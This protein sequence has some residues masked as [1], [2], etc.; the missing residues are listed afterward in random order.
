MDSKKQLIEL[1]DKAYQIYVPHISVDTVIFGFNNNELK[2]LLIRMKFNKQWFL[3][4]GYLKKEEHLNDAALRILKERTG[5]SDI[6]LQEFSVFGDHGRNE[7][8]FDDFQE[9][10]WNKQRFIS[11]GYYALVNYN[12]VEAKMDDLSD[13]CAWIDIKDLDQYVITMDHKDIIMKALFTLRSS[14]THQ[15]IGF[16]LL[17]E[18]FT[19]SELKKFPG[20]FP[21]A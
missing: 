21:P 13:D 15:P 16:N 3:P 18:K 11:V 7:R 20:I 14:I 6:F 9:L 12:K 8:Y 10:I 4:G 19:L 5:V 17:P 2:V 1:S